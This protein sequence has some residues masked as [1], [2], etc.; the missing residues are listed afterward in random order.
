[1]KN[2]DPTG[3]KNKALSFAESIRLPATGLPA[4]HIIF[5]A[6]TRYRPEAR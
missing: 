1:V 4:W 3:Y 6:K 5:Q 2:P